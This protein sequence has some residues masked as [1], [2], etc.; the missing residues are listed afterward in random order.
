MTKRIAVAIAFLSL[1]VMASAASPITDSMMG[2]WV[3]IN[4]EADGLA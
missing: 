4:P 3:N 1:A 2:A